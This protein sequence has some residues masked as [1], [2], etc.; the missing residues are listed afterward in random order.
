MPIRYTCVG[1]RED[2]LLP[3]AKAGQLCSCPFCRLKFLAPAR[4]AGGPVQ[5]SV[6]PPASQLPRRAPPPLYPVDKAQP[7]QAQPRPAK[8]TTS[9]EPPVEADEVEAA[10][11]FGSGDRPL[12]GESNL[13]LGELFGGANKQA[14]QPPAAPDPDDLEI[15]DLDL[16]PAPLS[17]PAPADE[18]LSLAD[19]GP[20]S[21]VDDDPISLDKDTRRL[22]RDELE[23]ASPPP[24]RTEQSDGTARIHTGGGNRLIAVDGLPKGTVYDL[25][26]GKV[27]LI[28]RDK[29]AEVK[30]LST[31]V[32]RKQARI[33]TTGGRPV[34]IDLGSANGT[35]VNGE[36]VD[37]HPLTNGDLIKMGV[38]TFRYEGD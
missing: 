16:E 3:D 17:A 29:Q 21:L 1:C 23:P 28:G 13:E 20:L 34:L 38:V 4:S 31:S 19:D 24:A 5:G 6:A 12:F 15:P 37:R 8:P 25:P 22:A 11:M 7:R 36:A 26:A 10:G 2:L 9:S 27:F 30:I 33:D 18:P 35:R 32:S 14:A